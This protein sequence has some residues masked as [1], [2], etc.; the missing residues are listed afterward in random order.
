M[1]TNDTR[2]HTRKG[3]VRGRSQAYNPRTKRW[4]KIDEKRGEGHHFMA[5][6]Y[7]KKK[8][9]KSVRKEHHHRAKK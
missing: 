9:Y 5:D 7:T 1:A 6:R 8:T 2:H 4:V 3:A